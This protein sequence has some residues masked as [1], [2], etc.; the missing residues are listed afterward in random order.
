MQ[1]QTFDPA[2]LAHFTGSDNFYRH[3][4]NRRIVYT[5][6]AAY[7]AES[8]GAYWLLDEIAIAAGHDKRVQREEFQVWKLEVHADKSATLSCEDGNDNV[9]FRKSIEFTDFPA[10]QITLWQVGGTILLPSEY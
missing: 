3:G 5:E 8:A 10:A 2:A 4:L 6:G 9:V 1:T 7:V